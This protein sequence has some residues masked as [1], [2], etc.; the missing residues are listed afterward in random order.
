MSRSKKYYH[1]FSYKALQKVIEEEIIPNHDLIIEG[2]MGVN[3]KRYTYFRDKGYE[4]LYVGMD[5]GQTPPIIPQGLTH[6]YKDCFDLIWLKILLS[7][8][9]VSNPLFV[10]NSSLCEHLLI[11]RY[12]THMEDAVECLTEFFKKQLHIRPAGN[13]PL[14]S[15]TI[16]KEN[17][18]EEY[19]K[20][21][22]FLEK[23]K[24]KGWEEDVVGKN[25][26]LLKR[27]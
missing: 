12:D 15:R 23:S 16:Y 19:T 3:T 17:D 18:N 11:G 14:M 8:Y 27:D 7:R 5:Y 6:E 25:I 10:T 22:R 26:V 24:E 4:G 1:R 2:G 20:F 13:F 21:M 9:S